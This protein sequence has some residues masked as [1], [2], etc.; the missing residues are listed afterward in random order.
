MYVFTEIDNLE[1]V[2]DKS[3]PG[4]IQ[5]EHALRAIKIFLARCE[6]VGFEHMARELIPKGRYNRQFV[7]CVEKLLNVGDWA[8]TRKTSKGSLERAA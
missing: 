2:F 1:F 3:K 6:N 7:R 8:R 5:P 4:L